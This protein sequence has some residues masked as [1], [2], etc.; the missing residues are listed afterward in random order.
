MNK[1]TLARTAFFIF[2]L[3]AV[4]A[5]P[6]NR[7]AADAKHGAHDSAPA[8]NAVIG[9]PFH[10]TDQHGKQIS[11]ADFRGRVMLVFFGFTHCPDICPVSVSS[12][13]KAMELLGDK[14]DKT[15][16]VFITVDPKRDTPKTMKD[17]LA[18]FDRRMVG[19]SGAP[20]KIKQ[21]ADAYKV[22]FSESAG[23]DGDYMVNHSGIIYMMGT[24]GKYVRHFS[25]D[26]AP[27]EIANAVKDYLK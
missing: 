1:I 8:S 25:Y 5:S 3:A 10:L 14:A 12:L 27:Q 9:G 7:A 26:A 19:L 11:D 17:Y 22:Y 20:A 16:P 15:A 24:D 18:A 21:A 2:A 23:G 4:L 13:S 6:Q